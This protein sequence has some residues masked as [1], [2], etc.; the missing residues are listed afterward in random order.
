MGQYYWQ[1]CDWA[2][3]ITE[4]PEWP[5]VLCVSAGSAGVA[6]KMFH[7]WFDMTCSFNMLGC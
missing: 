1:L 6:L 2:I 3:P 5:C 4:L 7:W